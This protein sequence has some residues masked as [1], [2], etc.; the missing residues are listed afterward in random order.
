MKELISL[1]IG[2]GFGCINNA[3]FFSRLKHQN[4]REKGTGN[5]GA[6]N[7]IIVLGKTF[8]VIILLLD[9]LKA[10]LAYKVA[11][12]LFS[13]LFYSGLLAGLGAMI[14][15]NFPFYM[16]FKGGKGLATFA[17]T[18]LAHSPLMF[19]MLLL[20][21]LVLLFVVN[22]SFIVPFSAPIIF[23]VLATLMAQSSRIFVFA[24]TASMAVL[25][26]W[27][28]FPNFKRALSG[29]DISVREYIKNHIFSK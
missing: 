12:L 8:G 5:L 27:K 17:G 23:S 24:V 29:Q 25:V 10:Y 16:R 13:N 6:T 11:R 15:H 20:M 9:I 2:Y 22:Y 7:A 19:L 28:H 18:V 4:M 21:V 14:G 26:I 1:L 3:A